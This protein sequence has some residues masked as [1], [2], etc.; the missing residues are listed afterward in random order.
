MEAE[1]YPLFGGYHGYQAA[2]ALKVHKHQLR[3]H[4]MKLV[5]A[6]KAQEEADQQEEIRRQMA[7]AGEK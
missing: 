2:P 7:N 6:E 5:E 3:W 4:A 1:L